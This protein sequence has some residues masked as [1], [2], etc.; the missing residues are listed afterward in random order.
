MARSICWPDSQVPAKPAPLPRSSTKRQFIVS[1]NEKTVIL[2]EKAKSNAAWIVGCFFLVLCVASY[3]G[4]GITWLIAQA[5]AALI[6]LPPVRRTLKRENLLPAYS[7][8]VAAA[9]LLYSVSFIVNSVTTLDAHAELAREA[10]IKASI[11]YFNN[12]K[13][14]ALASVRKKLEGGDLRGALAEANTYGATDPDLILLQNQIEAGFYKLKLSQQLKNEDQL[15][16]ERRLR[17]YAELATLEPANGLYASKVASL[18]NAQALEAKAL[19]ATQRKSAIEAPLLSVLYDE[20]EVEADDRFKG[21]SIVVDGRIDSINKNFH[22]DIVVRLKAHGDYRFVSAFLSPSEHSAASKLNRG[23]WIFLKCT[24]GGMV[25][26][27]PIL[28][29]CSILSGNG[30]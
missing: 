23:N 5:V 20:N 4:T 7:W 27:T 24:G 17:I 14:I 6:L 12:N 11:D 16:V 8:T 22:D 26:S 25:L 9:L 29:D 30:G 15:T 13:L 1:G 10:A 19:I 18:R 2:S 3:G 21:H 28:Q